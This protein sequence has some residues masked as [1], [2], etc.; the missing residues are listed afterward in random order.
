MT[1]AAQ[2]AAIDAWLARRPAVDAAWDEGLEQRMSQIAESVD[3][4]TG[5]HRRL[6]ERR[7]A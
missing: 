7:S 5:Q 2:L 4:E 6:G 3:D 1:T